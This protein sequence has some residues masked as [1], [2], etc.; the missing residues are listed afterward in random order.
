MQEELKLHEY[1]RIFL[2]DIF[3]NK[4][5]IAAVTLLFLL[6]GVLY[7]SWQTV[8]NTYNAKTTI[9]TAYGTTTQETAMAA[10]AMTGYSDIITSRKVL[11]RAEAIIGDP[12]ISASSIKK[13]ISTSFNKSSTVMTVTA[14]SHNPSVSIRASNAVAEAF[15]AEMQMIT[16]SDRIQVLDRAED[17][18]IS[19]NGFTGLV[20]TVVGF[21]LAGMVLTIAVIVISVLFSNKIMTVEQCMDIEEDD[22]LGIIPFVK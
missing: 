1:V 22:V 16:D 19:N 10:S 7:V 6:V 11:E 12:K 13:M 20:K 18:R 17:V 3:K 21:G 9:Y 15:V 14:A 2:R 4:F 5:I 8:T